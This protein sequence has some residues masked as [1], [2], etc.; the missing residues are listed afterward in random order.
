MI[1]VSV[2]DLNSDNDLV[3]PCACILNESNGYC[4]TYSPVVPLSSR[5]FGRGITAKAWYAGEKT[6]T[7]KAMAI[8]EFSG[9]N[10]LLTEIFLRSSG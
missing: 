6:I 9:M 8:Y 10:M 3:R 7:N 2:Y 5:Y 1:L 4:A